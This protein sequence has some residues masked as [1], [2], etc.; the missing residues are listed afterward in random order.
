M[1]K[2]NTEIYTTCVNRH[3]IQIFPPMVSSA[4]AA[5]DPLNS[6]FGAPQVLSTVLGTLWAF[7]IKSH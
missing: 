2:N 3:L 4:T 6:F 1:T 7:V 5:P